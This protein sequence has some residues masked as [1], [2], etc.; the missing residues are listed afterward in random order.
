MGDYER[1]GAGDYD[2]KGHGGKAINGGPRKDK[3]GDSDWSLDTGPKRS[4]NDNANANSS[5]KGRLGGGG[6]DLGKGYSSNEGNK[7]DLLYNPDDY[8]VELLGKADLS[9]DTDTK[10]PSPPKNAKGGPGG[11]KNPQYDSFS[12]SNF[13]GD[14]TEESDNSNF[15]KRNLA[16]KGGK[17]S[18]SD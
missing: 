2:R 18:A 8:Y 14:Y 4:G 12:G 15:H 6:G 11:K 17:R 10:R 3:F 1:R 7:R 13:L 9:N 16:T 5:D